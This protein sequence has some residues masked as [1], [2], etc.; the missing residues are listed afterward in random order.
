MNREI[1]LSNGQIAL[2][3]AVDFSAVSAFKWAAHPSYS[4]TGERIGTYAHRVD[5]SEGRRRTVYMHRQIMGAARGQMVDHVN[6][7]G[8]DNR[9]ANLRLCTASQ[10]GANRPAKSKSGYRGVYFFPRLNRWGAHL[11]LHRKT[12]HL[13]YFHEIE[14]AARA[15]DTAALAQF[16]EFARLNFPEQKA[17]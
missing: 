6:A 3:D 14:D 12:I 5:T 17:A 10:N 4:R 8:L 11:C 1:I 7:D 2:V 16:G 13:G 15:Y 9:R